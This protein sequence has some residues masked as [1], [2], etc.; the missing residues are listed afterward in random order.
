M[1]HRTPLKLHTVLTFEGMSCHIEEVTGQG[2]NA[3]V[4]TGW[5]QDSL[6]LELRHHVLVKELFP[7]HPQKKIYRAEDGHIT[8]DPEAEE[9]WKTHKESF[10]IGNKIHLRLLY[11]QPDLMVMGANLNSYQY[12]GTLYSVLGYTGGRSLQTE[13]NKSNV[14][15]RHTTQRMIGLLDALEAFHKS[16]YLHLDISPDNIMLVGQEGQERIFLIDYNSAREV[17]SRDGSYLSCKAGYSAPEVSTGNLDAIDFASDLYSV[18]AVFFRCIMGR[19]LTLTEML[20]PKAPDGQDSPMLKDVPQTVSSMVGTILKKGLHTLS[21]RRYQSIGQMRQAF[22]ELLDRIDCVGVTHWSLWENGKRSV[23]ELIKINPSLRYLKGEKKLYPIRLEQEYSMSLERYLDNILAPDGRSGMILAQG[24]MG[25]TTLLLHTA[26]LQ[27]KRY[28]AATPAV[29]YISL[30]GWDT[31]DTRYIRS[32]ILMR[33]RFKKEENTFDSAMH[34]LHKLLEQ[35]IQTKQGELPTVLLLLD[36]LNEV[37]GDIAPLVQEINELNKMAGVRLLATSRSEVPELE[38]EI[39]KLMPLNVED[40]EETLGRNGLLIPQKQDVIQLLR[41]PLILSIYIQASE[42]G[43]Q[44]NVRSEEELMR[45]Y[46]DSLLEKEIQQLPEDSPQ[47]WQIDVA[48]NYVLPAIA[49]EVKKKGHAL[50][51]RQMLKVVENCWK[52]LHSRT[53]Q[54]VFPQWI[55]HSKDIYENVKTA[56]EWHGVIIHDLLWQRLGLLIEDTENKYRVFHQ[57]VGNYLA[58]QTKDTARQILIHQMILVSITAIVILCLSVIGTRIYRVE[59]TYDDELVER[60]ILYGTEEYLSFFEFHDEVQTLIQFACENDEKNFQLQWDFVQELLNSQEKKSLTKDYYIE[61]MENLF[62]EKPVGFISWSKQR[63]SGTLA[64]QMMGYADKQISYYRDNLGVLH[65]TMRKDEPNQ[66]LIEAWRELADIEAVA[67]KELYFRSCYVYCQEKDSYEN[68][69]LEELLLSPRLT[70]FDA[71]SDGIRENA[72]SDL[73]TVQNQLASIENTITVESAGDYLY[74]ILRITLERYEEDYKRWKWVSRYIQAYIDD[75]NWDNLLKARTA[76]GG[77]GEN[78]PSGIE[79]TKYQFQ[80][81]MDDGIDA[82]IIESLSDYANSTEIWE[83]DLTGMLLTADVFFVNGQET[84]AEWLELG[85]A[86]Y[87]YNAKTMWY[88]TN[89]VLLQANDPD[90]WEELSEACPVLSADRRDWSDNEDDLAQ[91]EINLNEEGKD[92]QSKVN[93]FCEEYNTVW[94]SRLETIWYGDAA[95]LAP[96]IQKITGVSLYVPLP[97]WVSMQDL[98]RSEYDHAY[99]LLEEIERLPWYMEVESDGISK[100]SIEEYTETL[101]NHGFTASDYKTGMLPGY[102]FFEKDNRYVGISSDETEEQIHLALLGNNCCM[103]Y[104]PLIELLTSQ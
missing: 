38:L 90:F 22:Q 44:L 89:C 93:H 103:V 25:K 19:S 14:S 39:A 74:S 79:F 20:Q 80:A 53:M 31:A 55:G 23:E 99:K 76:C 67:A 84:L 69:K 35:P 63:Y 8:I 97:N 46:M 34:A 78:T 72:K 5:Y 104:E 43:R 86:V 33:L 87:D 32:Q 71:Y 83:M 4:Y 2:S 16:G 94:T 51:E 70:E 48:L 88:W 36:G 6:N 42:G 11:D 59:N 47:R 7:F 68:D 64:L 18:A 60:A 102:L 29:F 75:P 92:I 15:L 12:N 1:D 77:G 66:A 30:N 62:Q 73:E 82:E 65:N 54:K 3:I 58:T 9:L 61:Q 26:M 81:F 40:I 98:G 28:S 100:K 21:K 13:L 27:G 41:T 24:G 85:N 49:A 45:A 37:R 17:G 57:Q 52:V 10:E 56:E 101:K 50:T 91:E 96:D 95:T